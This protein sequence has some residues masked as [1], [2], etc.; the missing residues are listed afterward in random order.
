MKSEFYGNSPCFF[1]GEEISA[2]MSDGEEFRISYQNVR[3]ISFIHMPLFE[4]AHLECYHKEIIRK[5]LEEKK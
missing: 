3:C 5:Y 4:R 1:C 2:N